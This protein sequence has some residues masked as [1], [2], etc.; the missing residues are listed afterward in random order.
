MMKLKSISKD[1][2]NKFGGAGIDILPYQ[3]AF[4]LSLRLW[5]A[6]FSIA[7]RIYI[8]CFKF[9]GYIKLRNKNEN[10]NSR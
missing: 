9:W 5:N 3:I 8:F 2:Y 10:N 7:F 1:F 4:G 6:P